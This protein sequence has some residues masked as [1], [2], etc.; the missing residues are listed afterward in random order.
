MT[1]L[2]WAALSDVGWQVA[3]AVPEPESWAMMLAGLGLVGLSLKRRRS[4]AD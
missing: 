3:A 4:R 2:D 1:E